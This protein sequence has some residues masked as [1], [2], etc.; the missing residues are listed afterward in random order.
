MN[1]YDTADHDY[2]H[3][4][5]YF[6]NYKF[7]YIE[8]TTKTLLLQSLSPE[9]RQTEDL[10]VILNQSKAQLKDVKHIS[11]EASKSI[12]E[13]SVLIY[14]MRARLSAC[15]EKLRSEVE[16]EKHL[17]EE[18]SKLE[19]LDE[20][21]RTY[22]E[23]SGMFERGCQEIQENT[24]KIK[25]LKRDIAMLST[26]DAEEE[27]R[28]IRLKREKLSGKHRR[29]SLMMMENHL[30]ELYTWYRSAIEFTKKVFD[31]SL[32]TVEQEDNE[33]YLRFKVLDSEVGVF[34]RDGRMV[35]SKL[36]N[37]NNEEIQS[38]FGTLRGLAELINDPRILLMVTCHKCRIQSSSA[39]AEVETVL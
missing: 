12:S 19:S 37:T 24:E 22:D 2:M 31:I 5:D 36:Y 32:L 23:L 10:L 1:R 35:D 18:S 3:A 15:E 20:S 14:E 34:I 13:L 8:R 27:L 17:S 39:Q 25:A 28:N 9:D 29:L 7:G 30:E 16:R 33:M 21:L 6:N 11:K 26:K 4:K 38:V